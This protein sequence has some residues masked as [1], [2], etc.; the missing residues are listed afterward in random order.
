MIW[1]GGAQ[2]PVVGLAGRSLWRNGAEEVSAHYCN[3]SATPFVESSTVEPLPRERLPMPGRFPLCKESPRVASQTFCHIITPTG[4]RARPP[5]KRW[6][7]AVC[8]PLPQAPCSRQLCE[9]GGGTSLLDLRETRVRSLL[10]PVVARSPHEPLPSG[11]SLVHK[12]VLRADE[13]G[14]NSVWII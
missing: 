6:L 2:T 1:G 14:T 5:R 10:S 3:Y 8:A 12:I 13:V 11:I 9:G 7:C 4:R